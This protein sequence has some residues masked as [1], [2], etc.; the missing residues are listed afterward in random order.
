MPTETPRKAANLTT[1]AYDALRRDILSGTFAPGSPLR[2][3]SLASE[4]EVSLSVIREALVRLSEQGLV[5][6]SPNQGFRVVP[7]TVDDLTDLTQLRV[8]L[9][10]MALQRAIDN[11]TL[12]WEA[13]IVS[14]HHVLASTSMFEPDSHLVRQEWAIAHERFHTALIGA[15][16]S[17]RLLGVIEGLN[18]A[19]DVYRQW[20]V[21]P[22]L[23]KG[24]DVAAE[25]RHLMELATA[26]RTKD[27]VTALR[28]HIELTTAILLTNA[29]RR[30][31][32]GK[33]DHP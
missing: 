31:G 12:E 6:S 1:Q 21:E 28:A 20:A 16:G 15:C 9:E 33:I 11:G 4:R 22:G 8:D 26:R 25:H 29:E 27:A 24:R 23:E 30:R 19:A 13:E 18:A 7:L 2:I 5:T 14:S 17:P 10:A 3:N 32:G